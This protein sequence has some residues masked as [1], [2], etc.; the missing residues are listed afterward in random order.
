MNFNLTNIVGSSHNEFS[1]GLLFKKKK[2]YFLSQKP[3]YTK[4]MIR[5]DMSTQNRNLF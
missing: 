2:T 3:K 4:C 5:E 1:D